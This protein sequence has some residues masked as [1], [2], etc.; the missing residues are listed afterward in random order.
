MDGA[1]TPERD[2]PLD[3]TPRRFGGEVAGVERALGLDEVHRPPLQAKRARDSRSLSP[4]QAAARG[5]VADHQG[6]DQSGRR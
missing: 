6:M 3:A 5:R 2:D 1:V 4:R